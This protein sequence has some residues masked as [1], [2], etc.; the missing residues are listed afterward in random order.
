MP[1][2]CNVLDPDRAHRRINYLMAASMLLVVALALGAGL[3]Q[4]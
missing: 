3:Q 1:S 2:L 4:G